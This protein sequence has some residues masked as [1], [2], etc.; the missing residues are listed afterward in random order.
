MKKVWTVLLCVFLSLSC[1]PPKTKPT[2][3]GPQAEPPAPVP[4]ESDP[5]EEWLSLDTFSPYFTNPDCHDAATALSENRLE[6]ALRLFDALAAQ[7]SD[8]RLTLRARFIAAYLAELLGNDE[9]AFSELSSLA[10]RLPLVADLARERAAG[11]ALRLGRPEQA[12]DLA[13]AVSQNSSLAQDAAVTAADA[14]RAMGRLDEAVEAYKEYL[15]NWPNG[16]RRN[17][18]LSRT[19]ECLA[20]LVK[21]K[22]AGESTAQEAVAYLEL[23]TA[24]A[25]TSQWTNAAQ[26]FADSLH[27]ALGRELI[28]QR[29]D[30]KVAWEEYDRAS[31]LMRRMRNIEAERAFARVI[32]QARVDGDLYC[33]SRYEQALVIKRQREHARAA[34]QFDE[35]SRDCTIPNI[36]VRALLN[37]GKAYLS[38]GRWDDAIRLF[39]ELETDFQSHSYAD[40]ARLYSAQC[41]LQSGDRDKFIE[42]LTTLPDVYPAGDMRAE[43]LWTVAYDLI[44]RNELTDAKAVL[45]RYYE[46][47]PRESGWYASGRSGYWLARVEELLGDRRGAADHYEHV[48]V[49]SPLTFDMV[50]AYNRLL[51]IEEDRART[52]A[53]GLA[54]GQQSTGTRFPKSLLD[55]YPPLATG[56]ELHRLGLI[57]L[58]KQELSQLLRKPHLPSE[59]HWVAADFLRRS[60]AFQQSREMIVHA[61]KTWQQRYPLGSDYNRWSLAYPTAFED[62][63]S[64]AAAENTLRSSLLWAVMRE[65]SGFDP[66]VESWANAI[67]LMQVILP[68]AKRIGETI[69]VHVNRR[70][71]RRP[72]VNIT[73]GSAYLSILKEKFQGHPILMIAGYNAGEGAVTRWLEPRMGDAVDRFVEDIPYDQTRGYTKR[74]ISSLATYLFLY[75]EQH[76]LLELDLT[77]P[78]S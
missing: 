7:T 5:Y 52:L 67:G 65:E 23:L 28:K 17:E 68:T 12:L 77:L 41:H 13:R 24:Q 71:L 74:V 14:L 59:I 18:S 27:A 75:E 49:T 40:D 35:V 19:V 31:S 26:E 45:E 62:A 63:V 30:R 29:T 43:A 37:G 60:G 72:K 64:E 69:G 46:L 50:L 16:K 8:E 39:N 51:T 53:S 73:I 2:A 36:R 57:S 78:Q 58:A 48:I 56:I 33:R 76:P 21:T 22:R 20:T 3:L 42:L 6:E 61:D 38:A 55:D 9:R 34:Q 4:I 47:F 11:A 1:G 44:Q 15:Q 32:R 66:N 10:P 54:P 70:K 25:P